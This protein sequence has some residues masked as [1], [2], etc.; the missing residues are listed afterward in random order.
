MK[1]NIKTKLN[2]FY[3]YRYLAYKKHK[4]DIL[5]NPKKEANRAYYPFF[6]KKINWDNPKNL[7]EKIFWLQFNTDTSLWTKYADKY[8]VRDY[9]KEC[10]YEDN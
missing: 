5:K 8:Q 6:N 4:L 1:N 3:L 10:G 9:I 2:K 7:I